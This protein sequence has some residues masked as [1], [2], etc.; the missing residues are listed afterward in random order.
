MLTESE[1]SIKFISNTYYSRGPLKDMSTNNF[2]QR[3][4]QTEGQTSEVRRKRFQIKHLENT[5]NNKETNRLVSNT[6]R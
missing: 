4:R 5:D 2:F 1:V 3:Y 6:D